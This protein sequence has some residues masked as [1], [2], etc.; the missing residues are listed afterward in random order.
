[1]ELSTFFVTAQS[2]EPKVN[3][4][5]IEGAQTEPFDTKNKSLCA[6]ECSSGPKFRH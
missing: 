4:N 3:V 2:S 6:I 1:M 5:N